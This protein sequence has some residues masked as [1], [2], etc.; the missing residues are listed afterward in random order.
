MRNEGGCMRGFAV[1]VVIMSVLPAFAR[2]TP[3]AA[4]PNPEIPGPWS[5][6][7]EPFRVLGNIHYVGAR[8]IASYL[9]TTPEG[10]AL[11]DTGTKE[12]EPVVRRNI[13]KLGLKLRDIKIL[14]CG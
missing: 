11:I 10:H 9:I 8:N 14:L 2:G 3:P 12:M 13:E 1:A 4:S 7:A 5:A 6:A